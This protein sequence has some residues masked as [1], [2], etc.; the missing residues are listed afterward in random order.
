MTPAELERTIA[1]VFP[2][3]S[4]RARRSGFDPFKKGVGA[5]KKFAAR[6][7]ISEHLLRQFRTGK[8]VIPAWLPAA[9][10]GW[11]VPILAGV[12]EIGLTMAEGTIPLK[13]RAFAKLVGADG[14]E[15]VIT[16]TGLPP[17]RSVLGLDIPT[18][19]GILQ[20]MRA[21]FVPINGRLQ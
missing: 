15:I 6:L 7:G 3:R 9:V 17:G 10:T 4:R 5:N 8:V 13:V 21:G 14:I 18:P 12:P 2:F 19:E 20:E 1:W 16:A 11:G